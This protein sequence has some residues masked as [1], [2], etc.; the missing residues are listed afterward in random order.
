MKR[1]ASSE[2]P[3]GWEDPFGDGVWR[4]SWFYASLLT[5]YA[6]E[7][8]FY[9]KLSQEQKVDI[10]LVKRFLAY[11]KDHCLGDSGWTMPHSDQKFS[12]DQLVPFL[13]LLSCVSSYAPGDYKKLGQEILESLV[14][15]DKNGLGV[16]DSHQGKIVPNI[17]Y[18][19]AVLCDGAMYGIDYADGNHREFYELCFGAAL[20]LQE[21]GCDQVQSL[22]LS[23]IEAF[24]RLLG[25]EV[26]KEDLCESYSVFNALAAIS[27]PCVR[28]S[29][30]DSDVK[31]WRTVFRPLADK[32]WGP[33]FHSRH[34]AGCDGI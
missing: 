2:R 26:S 34:G 31:D 21:L 16:S 1:P 12:G 3:T 9:D 32:G 4:S 27:L 23:A 15:L 13:F 29:K 30:D 8:A 19:I 7:P 10:S 11:F 24:A 20:R 6:K 14:K 22:D 28:W 25:F 33:S 17:R 18:M 5:L